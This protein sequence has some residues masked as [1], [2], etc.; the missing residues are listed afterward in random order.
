MTI[1]S[2]QCKQNSSMQIRADPRYDIDLKVK[3]QLS[4][5]GI[6]NNIK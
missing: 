4:A 2:I 6:Q 1:E 3:S 5:K